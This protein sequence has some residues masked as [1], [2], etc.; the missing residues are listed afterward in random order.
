MSARFNS[1]ACHCLLWP[2]REQGPASCQ[3]IGPKDSARNP[4]FPCRPCSLS[5]GL[6]SERKALV[7]TLMGGYHTHSSSF[8]YTYIYAMPRPNFWNE[9]S[10]ALSL[11]Q[12]ITHLKSHIKS[13]SCIGHYISTS[14]LTH[15]TWSRLLCRTTPTENMPNNNQCSN[16]M[17]QVNCY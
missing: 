3:F 1:R 7:Y 4:V 5:I 15:S 10:S 17:M 11:I 16:S 2:S 14:T 8:S 12:R 13:F 6:F 9:D